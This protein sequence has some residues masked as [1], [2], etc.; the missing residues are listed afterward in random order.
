MPK[1]LLSANGLVTLSLWGIPDSGY[2]SPDAMANALAVMTRLEILRLRFRSPRSRPDPASRPLPSPTRFVLPALTEFMFSGVYEYLED[3][4]APIDTPRLD[5]FRI[6]FF[7]DLDF[8]VP[9]LHRLIDHATVFK[10]CDHAEVFIS[11]DSIRLNLFS[12]TGAVDHRRLLELQINCR[13]LD[14]QLSSLAQVCSHS[15]PLMSALEEL[16]IRENNYLSSLHREDDIE[17]TQWVELLDPFT[18]LENLYLTD[19]IAR[20]VCGALEGLSAKRATEV[21]PTLRNLFVRGSQSFEHIQEAI[22]PFVIARGPSGHP[23]VV[24]R[25]KD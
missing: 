1:L 12:K 23:I 4:L 15:F 8:D 14:Y 11:H 13:E 22:K 20:R 21:L 10:T 19:E 6:I 9:Q 3:L 2:F 5:S 25:W 17:D 16:Q 24:D 7:M 18:A